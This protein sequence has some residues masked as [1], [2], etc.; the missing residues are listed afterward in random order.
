MLNYLDCMHYYLAIGYLT[1]SG[2]NNKTIVYG[3]KIYN[4]INGTVFDVSLKE[5][6]ELDIHGFGR[7]FFRVLLQKRVCILK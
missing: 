5:A 6:S 7:D 3:F 2:D 4:F 1:K